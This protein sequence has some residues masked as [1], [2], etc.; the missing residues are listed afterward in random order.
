MLKI[1]DL[2]VTF[3]AGTA[4]ETRALD[5]VSLHVEEGSFVIVI[6]GNGSGKSTL[7]NAIAGSVIADSGA[8]EIAGN[9]VSK[10]PEHL[11]ARYIGRVFQN[12]FS[13]TAPNMTIAEN[14]I[15]RVIGN[16]RK[17]KIISLEN[18]IFTVADYLKVSENS[19][20]SKKRTKEIAFARQV[21]MYLAKELTSMTLQSIGLYFG[22]KD[23]ATVLYAYNSIKNLIK[24][25]KEAANVVQDIKGILNTL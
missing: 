9:N 18:I 12:P 15:K 7:Q 20:L 21:A 3:N 2:K 25:D 8:I 1:S 10:W 14:V 16:V 5:G 13:G 22:G 11:R 6:G 24:K 19:I 4:N 17:A 23:H